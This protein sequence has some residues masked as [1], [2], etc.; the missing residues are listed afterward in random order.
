MNISR[1]KRGPV[2]FVLIL[3][4]VGAIAFLAFGITGPMGIEDRFNK[5]VGLPSGGEPG[6]GSPSGVSVEGDPLLYVIVIVIL[7]TSGFAAYRYFPAQDTES[8]SDNSP[9]EPESNRP[10]K[11]S[12]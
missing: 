6:T 3:I 4:I 12:E 7:L 1:D 9:N 8:G 11:K 5:A 2:I 10:R